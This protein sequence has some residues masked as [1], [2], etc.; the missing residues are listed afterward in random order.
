MVKRPSRAHE[1][2]LLE[3]IVD[4]PEAENWRQKLSVS[5]ATAKTLGDSEA[6]L[7]C[8]NVG[9]VDGCDCL[10]AAVSH[11]KLQLA[12]KNLKDP[13]DARLPERSQSPQ[14]RAADPHR[15]GSERQAP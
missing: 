7:W 8:C 4:N 2:P 10:R 9:A 12:L 1:T 13:V 15:L 3:R 14:E 11:H 6:P 5:A